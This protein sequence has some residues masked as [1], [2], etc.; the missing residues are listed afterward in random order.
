LA[1]S[2]DGARVLTAC[3]DNVVRLWDLARG[4]VLRALPASSAPTTDVA[5]SPDGIHWT[6]H[7]GRVGSGTL[8]GS[9]GMPH[10][11][12]DEGTYLE[13]TRKDGRIRKTWR[14]PLGMSDAL[15][16]LYDPRREA[17]VGYGKMWTPW[18]DG[19]LA[20]KHGMGRIESK[21]FIQWSRPELVITVND[22]DPPQIEF[23]TSPVF[24]YNGM[25]F[26]LNQILD[27]AAGTMNTSPVCSR[28]GV[29]SPS[30]AKRLTPAPV[31]AT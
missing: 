12:T 23:H 31:R 16:V 7:E 27:R 18:P 21:D 3:V 20:W 6:K 9:K 25:Y 13:E 19:T 17:F 5:F 22:R 1:I 14:V 4:E 24:F 8:F 10:P 2:S 28:S 26:S 30:T 11:Y 29:R 15:D